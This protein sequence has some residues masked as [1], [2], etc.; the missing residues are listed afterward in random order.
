MDCPESEKYT[1]QAG[2]VQGLEQIGT[3]ALQDIREVL[4]SGVEPGITKSALSDV[5]YQLCLNHP[6]RLMIK[7]ASGG[8]FIEGSNRLYVLT[9]DE[10]L[11]SRHLGIWP[12]WVGAYLFNSGTILLRLNK[13]S[14][15]YCKNTVLHET[16]HSVSTY[17]RI[18][19]KAEGIIEK[20][21]QLSEGL[22]ECLTGYILSVKNAHC[23]GIYKLSRA[24][25]CKIAYR[26]T[27]KLFCSLAQ[28][29]GLKPLANLY[30]SKQSSFADTW[31][32]FIDDIHDAGFKRFSLQLNA[33][34]TFREDEF[35]DQCLKLPNFK[36]IY[37]SDYK[38]LDFVNIKE[39]QT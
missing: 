20:H 16:L 24:E 8:R 28:V 9:N 13:K 6:D 10:W 38:S 2:T 31:N 22:T 14:E 11:R 36:N 33:Q 37:G 34:K 39:Q 29:V 27:T 19:D 23:Y 35:R 1:I 26:T 30:L 7:S 17:S 12:N 32:Q 15:S 18:W 21:R 4:G 5:R 3:Q 25:K